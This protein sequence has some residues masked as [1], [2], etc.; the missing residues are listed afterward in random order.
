MNERYAMGVCVWGGGGGEMKGMLYGG[1][2]VR[3]GGREIW[4]FIPTVLNE[5]LI[6]LWAPSKAKCYLAY[7]V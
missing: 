1:T 7:T 2:P 6:C 3:P 5:K 4:V